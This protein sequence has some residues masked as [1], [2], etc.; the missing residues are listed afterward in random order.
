MHAVEHYIDA[1]YEHRRAVLAIT[2]ALILVVSGGIAFL[3]VDTTFEEVQV[4]SEEEAAMD[5][6]EEHF[7]LDDDRTYAQLVIESENVF[8][9]ETLLASLQLQEAILEH[10]DIA[11]TLVD[12]EATFG[13]ANLLAE[14]AATEA[15]LDGGEL[16]IEQQREL[17]ASMEQAEIDAIVTELLASEQASELLQFLPNEFEGGAK[18]EATMIVVAQE[19][20]GEISSGAASD[21]I[22][23]SQLAMVELGEASDEAVSVIGLGLLTDEM[24]QSTA[25]T[26]AL[27]GPL[28]LFAVL[29]ILTIA[30]RRLLDITLSLLGIVLVLLWTFG[31]LGWLDIAFNPILIAIPVFLIGMS[32]DFGIHVFMRYRERQDA[33]TDTP[34]RA[35]SAALAGVG[36]ALLWITVTTVTGFLSNLVSPMQPI[37]E[38]GLMA[39][40]GILGAFVVFVGLM[41]VVKVELES[42][43]GDGDGAESD[44]AI[45]TGDGV[46]GRL[47]A[48]VSTGATTIPLVIIVVALLITGLATATALGVD[49]SYDHEDNIADSA[50]GW[51]ENLPGPL[52]PGEYTAKDNLELVDEQFV[53]DGS[54]GEFL[55][56][57][58]VTDPAVLTQIQSAL[59]AAGE[60]ESVTTLANG[61]PVATDPLSLMHA[62]ALEDAAFAQQLAAADTTGDGLPDQDIAGLYDSMFELAPAQAGEVIHQGADGYESLRVSLAVSDLVDDGTVTEELR[63][64]ATEMET[65][66]VDV[67]ATGDSI[68][69][70]VIEQEII[71]TVLVSLFVTLLV[72]GVLLMGVY[73]VVHGSATLGLVTLLPVALAV[74]WIIATVDLLGY[75]LDVVTALTA[76]LTIGIGIDYSIHV[77]ERFRD[78]LEHVASTEAAIRRT[79]RGTGGALFGSAATTAVGFGVLAFAINPMLQQF[80]LITAIMIAFAFIGA[81]VLLPSLLLL[82]SKTFC[83]DPALAC[84][85]ETEESV[86]VAD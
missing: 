64:L 45:G 66:G 54:T 33:G 79:L 68:T 15:G 73:R 61:D 58:E 51:T 42:W 36:V 83:V 28:A 85:V 27:L 71:K 2:L 49:T 72:V 12:D 55:I 81:V 4:G 52:A 50:P 80:G 40:I 31:M 1:A 5:R 32:I 63:E 57:G 82:W 20:D 26:L 46:V 37:R 43:L 39:A 59:S 30:Y 84:S 41:P 21:D 76:S 77:S 14:V 9:R 78:E 70:H 16:S 48:S 44:H 74:A 29:L 6:L 38:L 7:D 34:G 17:I 35:M 25:D 23:E 47:L 19:V 24:D 11:P 86:Q 53:R 67:T 56:E 22:V 69:H 75:S 18:A 60:T 8:D 62:L 3:E 10:E 13:L 65:A